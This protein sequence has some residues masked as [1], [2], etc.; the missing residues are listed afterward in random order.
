M[1]KRQSKY[2]RV[3]LILLS[4]AA[5]AGSGW[6]VLLSTGFG[7]T[8]QSKAVVEKSQIV[9]PPFEK[10]DD[11][12]KHALSDPKAWVAPV[13][14]NKAVPLNKSVLLVHLGE[15]VYDLFLEDRLLRPPMSNAY[16]KENQLAYES[17]NVSDLDPDEDGFTNLEE[18]NKQTKPKD[19]KSHPPITDKI[20][21][22]ERAAKDYRVVLRNSSGQISLPDEPKKKTYFIDLSKVGTEPHQAFGGSAGDRFKALK[23]EKKIVPDPTT[24][25]RDVSELT[26]EELVTKKT[27]LLV[28]GKEENLAE[29][30]AVFQF[31]LKGSAT[32][33]P[34]AKGDSFRIP[35]YDDTTYKVID[36]HEANAVIS[37]LKPDGT[38]DKELVIPKG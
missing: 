37:A 36:I 19:A 11:A 4:I 15:E 13:R 25:E 21:M 1:Q 8:L 33:P 12:V 7:D 31:R 20:F 17:P 26:C 16:L 14:H 28:V 27:V 5:V 9:P 29:Y 10:V 24:G 23:F 32:L 6:L 38:W 3:T 30:K 35:G 2:E 34:V 22:I 18:F